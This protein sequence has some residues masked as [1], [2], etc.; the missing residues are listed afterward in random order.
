[1]R[2]TKS[3]W[4]TRAVIALMILYAVCNTIT[5]RSQLLK[6]EAYRAELAEQADRL[7]AENNALEQ[8]IAMAQDAAVIEK[9]A[10]AKLGLV[11]PGEKIF[12]DAQP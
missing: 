8:E 11:R 4:K 1:M 2:V 9:L 5:V 3:G 7:Q 12:C 6:A 10:R